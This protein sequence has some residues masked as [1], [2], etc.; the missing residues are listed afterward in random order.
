[1]CSSRLLPVFHVE[2]HDVPQVRGGLHG[3]LLHPQQHL[4]H[5]LGPH[6]GLILEGR[7]HVRGQQRHVGADV[8][9]DG[10]RP[11]ASWR[12]GDVTSKGRDFGQER[13][14]GSH[15]HLQRTLL[16]PTARVFQHRIQV[17]LRVGF[18]LVHAREALA[19]QLQ[20][21]VGG[22]KPNQGPGVGRKVCQR[23]LTRSKVQYLMFIKND[24]SQPGTN[25]GPCDR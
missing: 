15:Q 7:A 2:F 19:R 23:L 24:S 16:E 21:A 4:L 5:P 14:G 25:H 20:D 1:M 6:K 11:A 8:A 22:V 18:L 9:G 10:H 17:L 3:S 13:V 12:G